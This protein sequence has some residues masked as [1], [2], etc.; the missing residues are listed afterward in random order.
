MHAWRAPCKCKHGHDAHDPVTGKCNECAN[1]RVFEPNYACIGCDGRGDQHETVFE[2]ESERVIF[3]EADAAVEDVRL[4]DTV[5]GDNPVEF[6]AFMEAEALLQ[7]GYRA[8]ALALR[9]G[10]VAGTDGPNQVDV[11]EFSAGTGRGHAVVDV[12]SPNDATP[13]ERRQ[14]AIERQLAEEQGV[15]VPSR[16]WHTKL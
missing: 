8:E 6:R 14:R 2:T 10:L 15:V 9:D 13:A 5:V 16:T 12:V 1:C 11:L 7:G 3:D 4:D